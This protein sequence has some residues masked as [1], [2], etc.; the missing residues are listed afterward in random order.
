MRDSRIWEN[1]HTYKE[2]VRGEEGGL[3]Y[4]RTVM[5]FIPS[6]SG[7]DCVRGVPW[8]PPIALFYRPIMTTRGGR[9]RRRREGRG[10]HYWY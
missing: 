2:G 7:P 1:E 4:L 10:Y 9:A 5:I 3:V 8:G 6:L